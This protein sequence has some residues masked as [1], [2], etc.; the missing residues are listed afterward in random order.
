[1]NHDRRHE[2]RSRAQ[3]TYSLCWQ[4]GNAA[5]SAQGEATDVSASGVSLLCAVTIEPG[6]EVFVERPGGSITGY[7]VV[8][9]CAPANGGTRLGLEFQKATKTSMASAPSEDLDYYEFMQISPKAGQEVIHRVFRF[10][11]ARFHPD[12]PATG[13]LE[14]FLKLNQAY[15]VLSDPEQRANYDASREHH[16]AAPDPVFTLSTFV[17]GIEGEVNRRLAILAMLYNRRRTNGSEPG[18]SVWE[19]E[20]KMALPREYLDF[21]IWYLKSKGYVTMADN[22]DLTLTAS[23]VDYV[24]ENA[25]KNV[26][27]DKLLHAGSKSVTDVEGGREDCPRAVGAN[28]LISAQS[29]VHDDGQQHKGHVNGSPALPNNTEP[30]IY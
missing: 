4:D 24:E 15:A 6:T 13:D 11:A 7:C 14:K 17:N 5:R 18:I 2:P 1:M 12:N 28:R 10:T 25:D 20:R 27:L 26:T 8:R 30:I 19:L 22:S 16:Q 21:A 9:Y 23:G 3:G 29:N